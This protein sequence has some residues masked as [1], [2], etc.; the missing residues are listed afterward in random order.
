M[1]T[2]GYD[3]TPW[4]GIVRNDGKYLI[5]NGMFPII[6]SLDNPSLTAALIAG[7]TPFMARYG[8]LWLL[9]P[10]GAT[11]SCNSAMGIVSLIAGLLVL[12]WQRWMWFL[13]PV[14][15]CSTLYALDHTSV[16][17]RDWLYPTWWK[18]SIWYGRG[19]GAF[20]DSFSYRF[21]HPQKFYT[22]RQEHSS[23]LTIYSIF[24]VFGI[25]LIIYMLSYIKWKRLMEPNRRVFFACFASLIIN[26]FCN[27]TFNIVGLSLVCL[28]CYSVITLE[29]I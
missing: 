1:N 6:G 18:W 25:L 16:S 21:P 8:G 28:I 11:Y 2:L 24:G 27:L 9:L 3:P 19:L 12:Y 15:I 29:D 5:K 23:L 17:Q 4:F 26:S 10:I 20:Y 14:A 7:T 22:F 13:S